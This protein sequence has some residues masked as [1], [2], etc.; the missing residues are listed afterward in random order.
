MHNETGYIII[1]T[2][3]CILLIRILS[4]KDKISIKNG[5]SLIKKPV[6]V[7]RISGPKNMTT[8]EL[9]NLLNKFSNDM[10]RY[11][12]VIQNEESDKKLYVMII[13]SIDNINKWV[14]KQD[15]TKFSV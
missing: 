7:K 6:I 13:E 1:I 10:K 12:N 14:A 2:L 3:I 9:A 8:D 5:I 11:I 4:T 15:S